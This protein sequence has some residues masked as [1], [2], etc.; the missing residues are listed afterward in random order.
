[1]LAKGLKWVHYAQYCWYHVNWQRHQW[2]LPS[3]FKII[4]YNC[5]GML[6]FAAYLMIIITTSLARLRLYCMSHNLHL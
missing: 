3:M 2:P 5:K 4:I 1:M 6:R